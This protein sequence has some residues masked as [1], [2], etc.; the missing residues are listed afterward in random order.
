MTLYGDKLTLREWAAVAVMCLSSS[1]YV[2]LLFSLA[3]CWLF[4]SNPSEELHNVMK[5]EAVEQG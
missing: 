3:T 4:S 2:L 1:A 5:L